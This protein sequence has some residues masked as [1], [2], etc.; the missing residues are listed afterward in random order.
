MRN[1]AFAVLATVLLA[2]LAPAPSQADL[3]TYTQDFELLVQSDT[4]ALAGDGWMVFGNV[5]DP[6]GNYLYGYG[7][8]V[9]PND[10]A[11]FC[12]IDL[13]QGG[14]DQGLQQLVVF[15]DYNNVDHANG[16]LIESNVFQEW[17]VGT[18]DVGAVWTFA[19]DAKLG[20]IEG[21][22]TALA[23]IKTLD[24]ANG[25]A[26]T[27]FITVDMTAAPVTWNGYTLS[28]TIDPSLDGQLL[29]IG[30]ANVATLYE[31]AGI[32]YDNIDFRKTG[33]V[34]GVPDGAASLGVDL[35]QNYPNPF[36]P[37]T[38]ITFAL[39]KSE[40]VDISVYDLAGR[41]VATLQNGELG[42]GEHSVVWNGR[43]ADGAT[44]ASGHYRYVL[45][46]ATQTVSRGMILLK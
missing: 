26:L 2:C 15:S 18:A 42:A 32:F 14:D 43:T 7:P 4:A 12:Q 8:F 31:G 13:L 17:T 41:R 37:V 21:S 22:S 3:V 24:P 33:D 38:R 28:I 20:N 40:R 5:S 46:T 30:F 19:F 34:S 25:Y 1:R 45:K 27:N 36:N 29:Q 44:A 23:F 39:D 35:H 11:A 6:L 10:G 16:N 9:A